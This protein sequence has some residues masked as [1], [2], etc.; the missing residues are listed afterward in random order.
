[1][2]LNCPVCGLRDETEFSYLGDA[3]V[4]RPAMNESDPKAW[5][6]YVFIRDNPK[7]PHKELWHHVLGCRQW[8]VV[9]RD[10][11]THEVF[12]CKLAQEHAK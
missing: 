11:A 4:K 5:V 9:E 6:E 2:K 1:M 8:L 10:T 12:G 7:G 3:T